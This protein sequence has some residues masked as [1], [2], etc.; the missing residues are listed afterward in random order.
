MFNKLLKIAKDNNINLVLKTNYKKVVNKMI[1]KIKNMLNNIVAK[2]SKN[3]DNPKN[4]NI[5]KDDSNKQKTKPTV[6]VKPNS[7][8]N[9]KPENKR[10]KPS[11]R[12][13]VVPVFTIV[14]LNLIFSIG[15]SVNTSL[16]HKKEIN[17]NFVAS[18]IAIQNK[19]PTA[20]EMLLTATDNLNNSPYYTITSTGEIRSFV[21]QKV[22]L[23]K[24]FDGKNHFMENTTTGFKNVA[25]R[26]Y[27]NDFNIRSVK[28]KGDL[29]FK[30]THK[31]LTYTYKEFENKF[32]L[33]PK[34]TLPYVINDLTITS[35][36]A[37]KKVS[38]GYE[39]SVSLHP[40]LSTENYAK[41]LG[42]LTGLNNSPKFNSIN[43]NVLVDEN[44][45]FIK[46]DL[47]EEYTIKVIGI[48]KLTK[49]NLT[50]YFNFKDK[51]ATIK[52]I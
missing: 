8:K 43:L 38:A 9:K 7:Q 35:T 15:L 34:D 6:I 4:K 44:Y 33:S 24:V 45:N 12:A 20:K 41:N 10:F 14:A 48:G 1:S 2:F 49:S 29:T 52:T 13:I 5:N 19:V 28:S 42:T 17:A 37:P 50:T 32:H 23:K 36:T 18:Q 51:P 39:F 25:T 22:R 3:K 26:V 30:K 11:Y 47:E 40:T 27:A 31:P 46:I 16:E 21:N